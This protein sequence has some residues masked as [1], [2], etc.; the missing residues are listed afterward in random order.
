MMACL[1]GYEE[2]QPF[3]DLMQRKVVRPF[4]EKTKR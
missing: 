2:L 4:M 3:Y 1:E